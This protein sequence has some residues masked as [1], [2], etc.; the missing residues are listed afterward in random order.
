MVNSIGG[1]QPPQ[2]LDLQ[3]FR[4]PQTPSAQGGAHQDSVQLSSAAQ[5]ALSGDVDHDGDSH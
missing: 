2:S 3:P 5:R 4:Q 1:A